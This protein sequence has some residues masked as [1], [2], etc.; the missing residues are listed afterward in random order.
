MTPNISKSCSGFSALIQAA[1]S[2]LGDVGKHATFI[3]AN[4]IGTIS[5]ATILTLE[6]GS[7]SSSVSPNNHSDAAPITPLLTAIPYQ[8]TRVGNGSFSFPE[9]LMNLLVNQ[10]N[11]NVVTFLPDGKYFAIRRKDFT[12]LILDKYFDL[13]NFDN[14]LELIIKWGF[15]RVDGNSLVK[16][17]GHNSSTGNNKNDIY[18]FRH[19]HFGI[20]QRVDL[21]KVQFK[22]TEKA[23]SQITIQKCLSD[24]ESTKN[25]SF[26]SNISIIEAKADT[27][28]K[29]NSMQQMS[30]CHIKQ[31]SKDCHQRLRSSCKEVS[32][33]ISTS[34]QVLP[35][36]ISPFSSNYSVVQPTQLKRQSSLELRSVAQAIT[37]SKLHLR[38]SGTYTTITDR[39]TD[40]NTRRSQHQERR[41]STASTLV[42]GGVKSA[43][44]SIVSDAIEALLFDE[45]HTRDTFKRHEQELS[46][47]SLPGVVPISQQLF[48]ENTISG[49][50]KNDSRKGKRK[51]PRNTRT[52]TQAPASSRSHLKNKRKPSGRGTKKTSLAPSKLQ[53]SWEINTVCAINSSLEDASRSN[54]YIS[55]NNNNSINSGGCYSSSNLRVVIPS[56]DV[57]LSWQ[58]RY[59]TSMVV[60]PTRIMEA[61]ALLVSQSRNRIDE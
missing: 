59:T 17:V 50:K 12:D 6:G 19:A 48:S 33:S 10:A 3:E 11:E 2:Q 28:I 38:D 18:V 57:Q 16:T 13:A 61:A 56:D 41:R 45:S 51:H 24:E 20:N 1:T 35:D 37:A 32:T 44:R 49:N 8:E 7:S 14:F 39:N 58:Q 47:S 46:L 15:V 60:S 25:S 54:N 36:P 23:L 26:S 43:T 27:Q 40:N 52:N 55:N 34:T 22:D 30:P 9:V 5:P 53:S 4:R 31:D 21:N 29:N 42:E